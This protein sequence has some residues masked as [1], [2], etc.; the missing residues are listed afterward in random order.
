MKQRLRAVAPRWE[1]VDENLL[2]NINFL[3]QMRAIVRRFFRFTLDRIEWGFW[4]I[5]GL[6]LLI[7]SFAKLETLNIF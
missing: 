5:R 1:N 6:Y 4:S 3:P 2:M 7:L